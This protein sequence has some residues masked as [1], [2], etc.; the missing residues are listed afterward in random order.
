ML[1][2]CI[3]CIQLFMRTKSL[4]PHTMLPSRSLTNPI[5]ISNT[6][7]KAFRLV[8]MNA[9]DI[10]GRNFVPLYALILH[11][12]HSSSVGELGSAAAP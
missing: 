10:M 3:R 6:S 4:P 12:L 2:Y 1:L 9:L 8:D 5:L 11:P 7:I